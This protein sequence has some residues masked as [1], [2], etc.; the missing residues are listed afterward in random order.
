MKRQ[1]PVGVPGH[2]FWSSLYHWSNKIIIN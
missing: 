1:T 2:Q